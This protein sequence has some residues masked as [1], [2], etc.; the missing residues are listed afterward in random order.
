MTMA[1]KHEGSER[2]DT[3][4]LEVHELTIGLSGAVKSSAWWVNRAPANR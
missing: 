1:F 4:V 3:P 2:A